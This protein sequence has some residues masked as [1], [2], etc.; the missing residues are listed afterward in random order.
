MYDIGDIYISLLRC[1]AGYPVNEE[2]LQRKYAVLLRS[3]ECALLN[4]RGLSV[5]Y[6]LNEGGSHFICSCLPF[7]CCLGIS[8]PHG[9]IESFPCKHADGFKALCQQWHLGLLAPA[10]ESH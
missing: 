3:I 2:H 7:P 9:Q 10:D 5:L 8:V 1:P 4:I 6:W